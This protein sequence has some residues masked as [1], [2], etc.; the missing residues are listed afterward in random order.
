VQEELMT[1][2][3]NFDR[4]YIERLVAESA[5]R[6]SREAPP[7]RH[8]IAIERWGVFP[9]VA[10]HRLLPGRPSLSTVYISF[11]KDRR[12]QREA[13]VAGFD[14]NRDLWATFGPNEIL[15]VDDIADRGLTLA[16]FARRYQGPPY[17]SFV[18]F[19][20]PTSQVE[21]TYVGEHLK[22][23]AWVRFPWDLK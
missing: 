11:Y 15:V 6:I 4:A 20:K 14:E 1:D 21:P 3:V 18:L 10:L 5:L 22:D 2:A 23:G 19:K 12:V 17:R 9:A 8:I 7:V 16:E 13:H